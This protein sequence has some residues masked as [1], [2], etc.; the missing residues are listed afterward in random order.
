MSTAAF[1]PLTPNGGSYV[2]RVLRIDPGQVMVVR[3]LD[4]E[5]SGLASHYVR[6]RSLWCE[7]GNC[8][9]SLHKEPR[10]W[11]GYS[12]VEVWYEKPGV[13]APFVLEVTEALELDFRGKWRRGQ[14]WELE[15]L[16]VTKQSKPPVT[17]TMIEE[18]DPE[19][20][21]PAFEIGPTVKRLYHA[22]VT[23]GIK[24]WIPDRTI[25]SPTKDAGPRTGKEGEGKPTDHRTTKE[26]EA[27]LKA[28]GWQ[29]PEAFRGE[30]RIKRQ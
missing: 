7:P 11:K 20:F 5:L 25:V 2:L 16:P 27:A 28:N 18:R 4:D 21:P 12:P 29:A 23:F 19:S 24:S 10:Y 1:C 26:I 17:G 14:L 6:G 15:R 30:P 8:P 22:E 9:A 13:W 3:S